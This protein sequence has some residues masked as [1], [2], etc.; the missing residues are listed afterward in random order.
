M[1]T[2]ACLCGAVRL[3]IHRL[4]RT[5]GACH[6]SQCRRWTGSAFLG[7]NVPARDLVLHGGEQIRRIQS[8]SWAERAF[9]ARCGSRLW[10]RAHAEEAYEIPIGLLDDQ[11][12]LQLVREIYVDARPDAFAL[13]GEHQRLTTRETLALYRPD[14]G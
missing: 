2:G 1:H 6:C 14:Q 5:Y 8:S 12:G 10:Y 11:Q 7:V 4:R 9:C 3:E 13:A